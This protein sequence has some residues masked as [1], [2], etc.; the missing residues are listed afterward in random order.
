M[1]TTVGIDYSLTCP[2]I[3]VRREGHGSNYYFLHKNKKY[4][5]VS[6]YKEGSIQGD[7]FS[8]YTSETQRYENIAKWVLGVVSHLDRD[9]THILIEDYSF[10]SKHRVFALA[11][12][13]G[14]LK[15]LLYSAGYTFYTTA[16]TVI[17]KFATGKGNAK[18]EAMYEAFIEQHVYDFKSLIN[19]TSKL[20]SPLTDI[21]DAH[22]LAKYMY[23]CITNN[24]M[25]KLNRGTNQPQV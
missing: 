21:V 13:C 12:N 9:N 1:I 14:L 25:E 8:E 16:P 22:Y 7:E 5:G 6:S 18:K 23:E 10:G 19:M 2:C 4:S 20:D 11:E 17:K 15:Y 24:T 3:C